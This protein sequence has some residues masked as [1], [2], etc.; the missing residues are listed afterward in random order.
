MS[1]VVPAKS[2]IVEA[3]VAIGGAL[4]CAMPVTAA[5]FAVSLPAHVVQRSVVEIEQNKED[6]ISL[7]GEKSQALSALAEVAAEASDDDWDGY[8]AFPLMPEGVE[9]AKSFIR[10]LPVNISMPT[11]SPEPDGE[12]ALEWYGGKNSIFSLSFG[13]GGRLAYA[14]LDGTNHSK[15]VEQFDGE[16]ISPLLL[17]F[18]KR[19]A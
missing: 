14:L 16:S 18:I 1:Q 2:N 19:V 13:V 6:S 4:V 7:F 10:A 12:V 3:S 8:G 15:G 11:F 9:L 17:E 5:A